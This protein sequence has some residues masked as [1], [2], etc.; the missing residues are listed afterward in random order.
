[1]P[2]GN[3]D[4]VR[5]EVVPDVTRS[6]PGLI[7]SAWRMNSRRRAAGAPTA[8]WTIPVTSLEA[9]VAPTPLLAS[10]I[11]WTM[12]EW[13][14]TVSDTVPTRPSPVMTGWYGRTPSAVPLSILSWLYQTVGERPVTRPVT[15]AICD[16]VRSRSSPTSLP[17]ASALRL[18]ASPAIAC[19]RHWRTS[20]RSWSRS[21]LASSVSPNQPKRSRTGFSAR[22]APS[23]TGET[24]SRKPRCTECS[25]LL[26]D[27]PKYAVRR[28]REQTTSS[29]RT[30]RRRRTVLSY[31]AKGF[32]RGSDR[33]SWA[34][35]HSAAPTA[36]AGILVGAVD[37]LELLQ[38]TAG[39]HRDT[40]QGRFGQMTGHLGLL[41]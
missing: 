39:A 1:M 38:R 4:G 12:A 36:V 10:V 19:A 14:E 9:T 30:A 34:A 24:T 25:G 31:T 35:P 2:G 33:P 17:S 41:A 27:S 3:S 21:F 15:G 8:G 5:V 16:R 32:P 13:A 28:I 23:C 22:E 18:A 29:T 40:G 26:G 20:T 6:S 11:S 37:D 7:W